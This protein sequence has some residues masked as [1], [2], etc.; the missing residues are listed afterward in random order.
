MLESTP[1]ASLVRINPVHYELSECELASTNFEELSARFHAIPLRAVDGLE[2][3]KKALSALEREH[4]K[5][6]G[7][8]EV[9]S[10]DSVKKSVVASMPIMEL[11]EVEDVN[12]R[13]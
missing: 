8:E 12:K 2:R 1:Y 13:E 10:S 9:G 3:I 11:P 7:E 6:N 5:P 4:V